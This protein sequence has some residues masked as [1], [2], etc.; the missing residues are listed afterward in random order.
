MGMLD[1]M[2]VRAVTTYVLGSVWNVKSYSYPRARVHTRTKEIYR[3]ASLYPNSHSHVL[4]LYFVFS[5]CRV[6]SP[7]V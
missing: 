3:E 4:S 1:G 6:R 7:T 5:R 2:C